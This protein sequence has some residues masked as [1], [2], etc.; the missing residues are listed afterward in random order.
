MEISRIRPPRPWCDAP[1]YCL[2]PSR[3]CRPLRPRFG[4]AFHLRSPRD[5]GGGVLLPWYSFDS[6]M[7]L[8]LPPPCF[9]QP[10]VIETND[11]GGGIPGSRLRAP[12]RFCWPPRPPPRNAFATLSC[13]DHAPRNLARQAPVSILPV[14][15]ASSA[16]VFRTLPRTSAC[17]RYCSTNSAHGPPRPSA[18][19][20]PQES[21][22]RHHDRG[23]VRFDL[24]SLSVVRLIALSCPIIFRYGRGSHASLRGDPSSSAR[25]S[26]FSDPP[27]RVK[28]AAIR[29]RSSTDAVPRIALEFC[30]GLIPPSDR[31]ERRGRKALLAIRAR[32]PCVPACSSRRFP[33]PATPSTARPK[34]P[35]P[36]P[37]AVRRGRE[38]SRQDPRIS[39]D[40]VLFG[41]TRWLCVRRTR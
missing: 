24:A 41:P 40:R 28:F 39:Q 6:A 3:P 9:P 8:R 37:Q 11:R 17:C 12:S 18:F 10:T 36:P 38:S 2:L 13:T 29:R 34:A 4:M 26:G 7:F 20:G 14:P 19:F 16:R 30:R 1:S 27:H 25:L 32:P 5:Y 33:V 22:Q 35:P 15:S 23:V 31:S 21:W